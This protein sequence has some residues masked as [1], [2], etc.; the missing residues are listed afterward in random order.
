M[1][2]TLLSFLA[3]LATA[4]FFSLSPITTKLLYR[5][6]DPLPLA[7]VRFL[8]ASICIA[9]FI[10]KD[11]NFL[12]TFK[13]VAPFAIFSTGNIFF[14]V[15]GISMTNVDSSAI[16]YNNVPLIVAVLSYFFVGEKFSARK[17]IG[18]LLGFLGVLIIVVLPVLQKGEIQGNF[19][20][21]VLIVIASLS[22][23]IYTIASKKLLANRDISPIS[24]TAVSFFVSTIVFFICSI[25]FPQKN[26]FESIFIGNNLILIIILGAIGTVGSYVFFQWAIKISSATIASL[27]QYLQTIITIA[28]ATVFLGEKLIPEFILG[29][30][31]VFA[32]VFIA[33]NATK[34]IAGEEKFLVKEGKI[35]AKE[36][37]NR[38]R[39]IGS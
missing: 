30:I 17:V 23:S 3:I 32:G 19:L 28:M 13:T 35:L 33:T 8:I 36:T 31:L 15:L 11:K 21:N 18:I 9:P 24:M 7:F 27:N 20:G 2:K 26:F 39:K 1:N 25:L 10:L 34:K 22:W 29:G 16:I 12:K 14:F 6:F 5:S 38:V 37:F 4:F